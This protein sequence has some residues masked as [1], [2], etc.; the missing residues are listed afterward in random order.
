MSDE[1]NVSHD[2]GAWYGNT[3]MN[4]LRLSAIAVRRENAEPNAY[5]FT[6]VRMHIY[7]QMCVYIYI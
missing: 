4:N 7:T 2:T 5:T 3:C 1:R 6:H